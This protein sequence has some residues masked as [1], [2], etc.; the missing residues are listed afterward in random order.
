MQLQC[1]HT[2][3]FGVVGNPEI[4]VYADMVCIEFD[5]R[6]CVA[7]NNP[8]PARHVAVLPKPSYVSPDAKEG[9]Q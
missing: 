9:M 7:G 3:Q 2:L 6:S 1:P 4:N 5:C 8:Y